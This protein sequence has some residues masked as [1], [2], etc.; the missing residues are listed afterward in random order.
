[1]PSSPSSLLTRLML[2][3]ILRPSQ[4]PRGILPS[5][6]D[7]INPDVAERACRNLKKVNITLFLSSQHLELIPSI[8]AIQDLVLCRRPL[9]SWTTEQNKAYDVA[10]QCR[11][12]TLPVR[13]AGSPPQVNVEGI[14]QNAHTLYI[15]SMTIPWASSEYIATRVDAHGA[16]SQMGAAPRNGR[17]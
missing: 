13:S 17:P 15:S 14:D 2:H 12:A 10:F 4:C 7:I 3:R 1:M 5:L 6:Q 8:E 11:L 9:F 16:S